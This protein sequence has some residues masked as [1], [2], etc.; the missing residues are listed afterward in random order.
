MFQV[1]LLIQFIWLLLSV[2]LQVIINDF[3]SDGCSSSTLLINNSCQCVYTY[4]YIGMQHG[5]Q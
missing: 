5:F 3:D 2:L 1:K 4:V